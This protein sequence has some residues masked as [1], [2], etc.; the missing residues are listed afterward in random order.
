MASVRLQAIDAFTFVV[1]DLLAAVTLRH[2][3]PC[4]KL[5]QIYNYLDNSNG[6]WNGQKSFYSHCKRMIA[7]HETV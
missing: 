6:Q 1:Q 3:I 4:G 2:S 5:T 7:L